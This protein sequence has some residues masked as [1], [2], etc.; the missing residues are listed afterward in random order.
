MHRRHT[1]GDVHIAIGMNWQELEKA[2]I[3]E[4][5]DNLEKEYYNT[6]PTSALALHPFAEL[7]RKLN[8]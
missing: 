4:V 5:I 7:K 6:K 3:L 8:A 1:K 2:R